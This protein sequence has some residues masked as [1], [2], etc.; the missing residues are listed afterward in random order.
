M[1][2]LFYLIDGNSYVYRF[3]FAIRNLKSS[4]GFPTN[5]VY[6]FAGMM[7]KLLTE[8]KPDCVG[9]AFDLPE[10]TF[11]RLIFS[12]YKAHRPSMPD[13]LREQFPV[14]KEMVAL[15][16]VRSFE[17][18]GY[19]ADDIIATLARRFDESADTRIL[20]QDKDCLQLVTARTKVL[21]ENKVLRLC[22]TE[23]VLKD[24]GIMPEQFPDV[25]AL[26]G[27]P[28]DNIKGIPGVG[29]KTASRLVR[30]FG[31]LEK[32]IEEVES[33]D[34]IRIRASIKESSDMLLLNKRLTTLESNVPIDAD[35]DS[36][37]VGSVNLDKLEELFAS[38]GFKKLLE[39]LQLLV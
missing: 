37:R 29:W 22:D 8:D 39:K 15:L 30:K 2:P 28:S 33:V 38:L 7:I 10:P 9:V 13:E 34:N 11:R 32:M 17:L 19:E 14:I 26:C 5:A 3:Y 18:A 6:G 25:Q 24:Y 35:L 1:L 36:V 31:S 16:G 21:R 20:S 4:R 27:D 23:A 12:E